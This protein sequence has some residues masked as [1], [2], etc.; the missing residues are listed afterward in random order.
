MAE[1]EVQ[2][3]LSQNLYSKF[4]NGKFETE[5]DAV[6]TKLIGRTVADRTVFY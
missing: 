6:L 2:S 1:F 4:F 3:E 5:F